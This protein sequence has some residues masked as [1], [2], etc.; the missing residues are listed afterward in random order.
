MKKFSVV[1]PV[2]NSAKY[3]KKCLDSLVNQRFKDIEIIIVNDG[4]TDN[5][6]EIINKYIKKYDN[7][8]I[9]SITNHGQ[10]FARNYGLSKATGEYISFVDSDDYVNKNLF[11]EIDKFLKKGDYDIV[12]FDYCAVSQN[13]EIL[14]KQ[15]FKCRDYKNVTNIEYLF[16]DPC[17]WNKVYKKKFLDKIKFKLPEGIIYEDYCYIPTLVKSDPIIGYISK[18]LYY[19]VYSD[20]STTR[21]SIYKEKYEDLLKATELLHNSFVNTEYLEEIEYI[22]Y[23]HFLYFGSLNFY[24]Y[25]KYGVID[26]ISNFMYLNYPNWMKNKYV[27]RKGKKEKILAY[28]F[29]K[30]KYKTIKFIQIIK[31]LVKNETI[32][33]KNNKKN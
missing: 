33:S 29:Y 27:K 18:E 17:P 26:K 13:D 5:S 14:F 8:S 11:F 28:L 22:I 24:K 7:I 12:L 23:Y 31:K 15:K 25:E 4:S 2:Y 32:D 19:Y 9:Y 6:I 1:I 20:S 21:N 10:S 16:G 30:K 3:L